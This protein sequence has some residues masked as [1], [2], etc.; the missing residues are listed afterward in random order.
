MISRQRETYLM[1]QLNQNRTFDDWDINEEEVVVGEQPGGASVVV[2]DE[3]R[4]K[5]FAHFGPPD[6]MLA[7]CLD[8][9]RGKIRVRELQRMVCRSIATRVHDW[10][11]HIVDWIM[12]KKELRYGAR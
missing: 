6:E 2:Q 12:P 11:H 8:R 5:R 9:S 10:K 3:A 4:Q 1:T 7:R